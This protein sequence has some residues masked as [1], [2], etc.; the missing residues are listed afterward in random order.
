MAFSKSVTNTSEIQVDLKEFVKYAFEYFDEYNIPKLKCELLGHH[1]ENFYNVLHEL[2]ETPL[3][4]KI[5]LRII[6]CSNPGMKPPS[7]G[8]S[9]KQKHIWIDINERI[10]RELGGFP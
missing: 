5:C 9:R 4:W 8:L 7:V 6:L 3:N 1:L 10:T 2:G